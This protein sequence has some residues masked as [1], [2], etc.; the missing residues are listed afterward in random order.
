MNETL[1]NINNYKKIEKETIKK[2]GQINSGKKGADRR[3]NTV[4]T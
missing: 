1:Y 4:K 2:N 3:I